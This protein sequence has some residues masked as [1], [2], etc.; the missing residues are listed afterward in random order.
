LEPFTIIPTTA[1]KSIYEK[2]PTNIT[3]IQYGILDD[4]LKKKFVQ[5]GKSVWRKQEFTL[6]F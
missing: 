3:A 6:N 2:L 1:K 4:N 5:R